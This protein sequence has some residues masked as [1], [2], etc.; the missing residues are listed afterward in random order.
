MDIKSL[1]ALELGKKIRA[2]E[3][4]AA[5]A[6]KAALEQI[7]A[8]DGTVHA[9]VTVDAEGALKRAE[10]V[11]KKIDDGTLTGLWR[12]FR[13]RSKTICVPRGCVLRAAR[14][15]SIILHPPI[16]R[17]QYGIWKKQAL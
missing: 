14:R 13:W 8:V 3:I 11:Q 4:G 17:K 5:E 2:G 7:Q 1:T 15:F 16:R 9:F 6:A 12:A 10:K